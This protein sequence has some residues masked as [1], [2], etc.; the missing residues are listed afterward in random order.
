MDF[1][2]FF[3]LFLHL[4]QHLQTLTQQYGVWIYVLLSLVIFCETGLV[5]M[6][7]LPGDS[8]LFI[9]GAVFAANGMDP[10]LLGVC[11]FFAA[12][13][14]DSTNYWIGRRYGLGLF[15]RGNPKIFRRDFLLRTEI[16][17][18]RHGA[19]TVTLARFFAILRSFAPFVAGIGRMPYPRFVAFSLLGSLLWISSLLSLGYMFGNAPFLR[20]N[21]TL[22]VLGFLALCAIPVLIRHLRN[23]RR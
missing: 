6:V 9:A 12:G 13:L 10:W 11:L 20:D 8:L 1:S 23:Q 2:G 4:D 19:K 3:D 22:L 16:F 17:Y 14:G 15:E 7:W 21:L 5:V 18:A